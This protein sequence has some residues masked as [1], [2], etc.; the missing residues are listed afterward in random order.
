MDRRTFI[1]SGLL[2]GA[3]AAAGAAVGCAPGA[4]GASESAAEEALAATGDAWYGEPAPLDSFD[5]V[6]TEE[7]ELLICGCGA[8]GIV[9]TATAAEEG[10]QIG[11]AHV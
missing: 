4:S 7:C 11:R 8:G 9:A 6:D 3:V 2:A 1:K 5:L 10:I